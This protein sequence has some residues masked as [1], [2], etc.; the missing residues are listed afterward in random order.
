MSCLKSI[1]NIKWINNSTISTYRKQI[2]T[3]VT[4]K[5]LNILYL[6]AYAR[7]HSIWIWSRRRWYSVHLPYTVIMGLFTLFI[8]VLTLHSYFAPILKSNR[9][10]NQALFQYS[11]MHF[12]FLYK[13]SILSIQICW[14][15]F[16]DCLHDTLHLTQAYRSALPM[17]KMKRLNIYFSEMC[18]TRIDTHCVA[19]FFTLFIEIKLSK[20]KAAAF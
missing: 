19:I 18:T 2:A 10:P 14:L 20:N 4:T 5:Y 15:T 3:L 7:R 8:W 9:F 13:F 16:C 11:H 1:C 6:H 17:W 12:P